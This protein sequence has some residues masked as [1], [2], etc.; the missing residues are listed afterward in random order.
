MQQVLTNRLEYILI[1]ADPLD[2]R[3]F[4]GVRSA[5]FHQETSDL[6]APFQALILS[7]TRLCSEKTERLLTC[8]SDNPPISEFILMSIRA[9]PIL[10]PIGIH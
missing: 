9:T 10:C 8:V 2:K 3:N 7:Q 1:F 6:R 5:I 4:A